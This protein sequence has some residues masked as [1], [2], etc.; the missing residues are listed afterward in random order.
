MKAEVGEI[1]K[2]VNKQVDEITIVLINSSKSKTIT[3]IE[4][5]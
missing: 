2:V 4:K 1:Y 5:K 3:L